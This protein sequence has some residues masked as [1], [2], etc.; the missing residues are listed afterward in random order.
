MIFKVFQRNLLENIWH[1]PVFHK[2]SLKWHISL[3]SKMGF[4]ASEYVYHLWPQTQ[5]Y[6]QAFVSMNHPDSSFQLGCALGV[7]QIDRV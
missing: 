1:S 5:A 2:S 7:K 6:A 4:A 3:N